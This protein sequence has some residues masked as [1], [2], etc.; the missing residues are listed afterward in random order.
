MRPKRLGRNRRYE[1]V[2]L[3]LHSAYN[4]GLLHVE[5]S[6][7]LGDSKRA[8]EAAV[9]G[10][11]DSVLAKRE[12]STALPE[13]V[14]GEAPIILEGEARSS[15]CCADL[16]VDR[17]GDFSQSQGQIGTMGYRGSRLGQEK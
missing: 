12:A 17:A 9:E 2:S 5:I 4:T 6:V 14:V 10:H 13:A 11:D 7:S 8:L 16:A 1:Q 15:C 3:F